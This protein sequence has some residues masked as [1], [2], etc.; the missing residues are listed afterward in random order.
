[1]GFLNFFKKPAVTML[2]LQPGSFTVSRDGMVIVATLPSEFPAALVE[3]IGAQ[4]LATFH[5]AKAA[6]LLLTEIVIRYPTLKITAIDQ[7][8]GAIVFLLPQKPANSANL[9]SPF[10]YAK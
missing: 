6:Q 4:V 10:A 1:M 7:R 5:E 8:G 9:N 2:R 3:E